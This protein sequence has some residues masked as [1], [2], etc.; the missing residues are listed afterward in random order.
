MNK[1][2]WEEY[3]KNQKSTPFAKF[4]LKYIPINSHIVDLGCGNGRDTYFFAYNNF[5]V[6]GVDY[7]F[8]PQLINKA[9]FIKTD[10]KKLFKSKNK[11]GVTYS[12]FCLH[13]INNSL[14]V[15][16]IEWSKGYFMA[17]FRVRGD[18]PILFKDHKRNYVD[19]IWLKKLLEKNNFKILFC[20]TSRNYAKYNKESPLIGRVIAYKK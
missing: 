16:L 20:K 11:W 18:K 19:I 3:Y 17:E 8:S 9:A 15:K 14:I 2:Y 12:R 13:S 1:N 10:L 6:V 4:C 5:N 7:A